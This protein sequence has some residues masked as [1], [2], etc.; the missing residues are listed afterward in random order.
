MQNGS[1]KGSFTDLEI[2]FVAAET[3]KEYHSK[4]RKT[5]Y[6]LHTIRYTLFAN[7]G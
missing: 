6:T 3:K 1:E 4:D 7:L 2:D 5:N